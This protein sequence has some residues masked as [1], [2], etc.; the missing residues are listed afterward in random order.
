MR[1]GGVADLLLAQ[2]VGDVG[3]VALEHRRYSLSIMP[4]EARTSSSMR[5]IISLANRSM[6]RL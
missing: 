5:A 3:D 6:K 2:G 1:G 4:S